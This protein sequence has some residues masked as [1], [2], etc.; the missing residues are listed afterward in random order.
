MQPM[1]NYFRDMY[2]LLSF[3]VDPI[4]QIIQMNYH[5]QWLQAKWYRMQLRLIFKAQLP[6]KAAS[7]YTG[8]EIPCFSLKEDR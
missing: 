1:L 4:I 3:T 8:N 6:L 5:I 2:E 7:N